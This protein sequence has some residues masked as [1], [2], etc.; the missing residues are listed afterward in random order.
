MGVPAP[1]YAS[2]ASRRQLLLTLALTGDERRILVI[3]A[4]E[5][6]DGWLPPAWRQR[7]EVCTSTGWLSQR[8]EGGF[9]VVILPGSLGARPQA[10]GGR[11]SSPT[12][13]LDLVRRMLAPGGVLTGHVSRPAWRA[14]PSLSTLAASSAGGCRRLL[15]RAGFVDVECYHVEPRLADPMALVPAGTPAARQHFIRAVERDRPQCSLPGYLVRAALARCG[16]G[17]LMQRDLVFWARRPC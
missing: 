10:G 13:Q 16:G 5:P 1:S 9:E 12:M 4:D 17:G 14:R 6:A 2:A 8:E 7:T 11:G 3:G 15:E